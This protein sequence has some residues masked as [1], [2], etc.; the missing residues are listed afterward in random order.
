MRYFILALIAVVVLV[1]TGTARAAWTIAPPGTARSKEIHELNIME[2][3]NRPLH[4]YG[5]VV[6]LA[7]RRR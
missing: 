4:V 1:E 2:R 7:N 5:D 3:P 6:R